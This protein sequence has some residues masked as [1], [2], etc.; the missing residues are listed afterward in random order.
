MERY[1]RAQ[2]RLND[3]VCYGDGGEKDRERRDFQDL[4]GAFAK[5]LSRVAA[6]ADEAAAAAEELPPTPT[7]R[8]QRPPPP[9]KPLWGPR[10]AATAETRGR[11]AAPA[12][13]PPAAAR[14]E[15]TPGDP[16]RDDDD[17]ALPG[18]APPAAPPAAAAVIAPASMQGLSINDGAAV[19]VASPAD[20]HDA[21]PAPP[22]ADAPDA[23][24]AAEGGADEPTPHDDAMVV[25]PTSGGLEDRGALTEPFAAAWHVLPNL[26]V[27]ELRA[28][29]L[30][31]QALANEQ[32]SG[33]VEQGSFLRRPI[34]G[35]LPVDAVRR[36]LRQ[37]DEGELRAIASVSYALAKKNEQELRVAAE[38]RAREAARSSR[39]KGKGRRTTADD[40][41]K[42]A[43]HITTNSAPGELSFD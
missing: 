32:Q 2:E 25:G 27:D 23:E 35:D 19:L 13:A 8:P 40:D 4:E 18:T 7:E 5:T 38:K 43:E 20:A 10:G 3:R 28:L 37:M 14:E 21:A 6:A 22:L 33:M 30:E 39:G 12:A 34:E 15:A 1:Q 17:T 29:D 24:L 9:T 42:S 11:A 16:M 26:G 31:G 41:I 36:M